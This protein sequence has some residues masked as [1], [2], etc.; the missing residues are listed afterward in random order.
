MTRWRTQLLSN[1]EYL[2]TSWR[3]TLGD[4][5]MGVHRSNYSMAIM[6]WYFKGIMR[7]IFGYSICWIPIWYT[8]P[9]SLEGH[10]GQDRFLN[11]CLL[12]KMFL[13]MYVWALF[14]IL[15]IMV[16][17][18]IGHWVCK[19]RCPFVFID[20]EGS[21]G[22]NSYWASPTIMDFSTN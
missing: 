10:N 11:L 2:S 16:K 5:V 15:V 18:K 8:S 12:A 22:L 6:L 19:S 17:V 4:K 13:G 9:P 21:D 3:V 20:L 1:T 7:G 14:Q